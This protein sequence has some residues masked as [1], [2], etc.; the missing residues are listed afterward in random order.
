MLIKGLTNFFFK[1]HFQIDIELVGIWVQSNFV[2]SVNL[3]FDKKQGS[4][5]IA[6]MLQ[7]ILEWWLEYFSHI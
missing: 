4:V 7:T 5:L 3:N 6:C 1:L 2:V